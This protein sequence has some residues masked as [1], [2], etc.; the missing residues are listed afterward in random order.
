MGGLSLPFSG[1]PLG[2]QCLLVYLEIFLVIT[3][4]GHPSPVTSIQRLGLGTLSILL[5]LDSF[6]QLRFVPPQMPIAGLADPQDPKMD[7]STSQ[8]CL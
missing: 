4:V 5:A 8:L 2:A 1:L 7:N 6:I 3:M